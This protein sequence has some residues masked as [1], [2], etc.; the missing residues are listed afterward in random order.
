VTE[1]LSLNDIDDVS[2]LLEYE[3]KADTDPMAAFP[4]CAWRLFR[5]ESFCE[6]IP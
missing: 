2:V 1:T 3:L 6:L 5:D 4:P